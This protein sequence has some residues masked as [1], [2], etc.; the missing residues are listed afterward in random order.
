[1][2]H[3][4]KYEYFEKLIDSKRLRFA[5]PFLEWDDEDHTEMKILKCIFEKD[6]KT[7]EKVREATK[8]YSQDCNEFLERINK[9]ICESIKC[10]C[11]TYDNGNYMWEKDERK[12]DVRIKS[13]KQYFIDNYNNIK[14]V[15]VNYL[16]DDYNNFLTEALRLFITEKGM[17]PKYLFGLKRKAFEQ[18]KEVRLIIDKKWSDFY[19]DNKDNNIDGKGDVEYIDISNNINKLILEVNVSPYIKPNLKSK[20]REIC[21]K[22]NLNYI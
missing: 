11:W 6:E 15:D 18:E 20:V 10:Q 22:N 2:Y 21:R 17:E 9:K 19:T 14:P 5:N 8:K 12:Y 4:L 7:I 1:M 3:Y 16:T 13:S